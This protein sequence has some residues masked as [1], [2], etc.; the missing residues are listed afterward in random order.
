[1]STITKL[2]AG[3]KPDEKFFSLEFFPPKT[4]NGMANFRAR[5]ARMAAL[6]PLFITITW[7]AGGSTAKKSLDIASECQTMGLDV[8]L[9]L[10][11]TNMDPALIDQALEAASKA[12]ICN[13]LA[14][15]GDPP[16]GEEYWQPASPEFQHAADLVKYIK[17]KHGD[18]FCVGVAGYPEGHVDGSDASHQD[19]HH[20]LPYLKEKVEA[21]ADFIITQMFYDDTKFLEYNKAVREFS[22]LLKDITI[23]PGLMPINTYTSFV[24]AARLSHASVPP[25]ILDRIQA[26]PTGNDQQVK[27]IG[28]EVVSDIVNDVYSKTNKTVRGFH[29]YTLNLERSVARILERSGFLTVEEDIAVEEGTGSTASTTPNK[30]P[31]RRRSSASHR[32]RVVDDAR[33]HPDAPKEEPDLTTLALAIASGEGAVGREAVWDDFPN[34]RFGDS[35]SPAFGEIDGYGPSIHVPPARALELWGYPVDD[36]D[37]SKL[38][39]DTIVGKL[40]FMPWSDQT[41][42][43]E[44]MLIQE[45]LMELNQKGIWTVASQ[46]ACNALKSDD[47]IFGWGPKG[48]YVFQKS[49][50]EFF[51]SPEQWKKL[52]PLLDAQE[53]LVSYYVAK[54]DQLVDTNVTERASNG[55]TWGV[56]PNREIV[57]TTIIQEDSFDAWR[58]EAFSIW[59]EWR[60]LYKKNTASFKLLDK[61][62]N[63]YLLVTV[64][65]HDYVEEDGLWELLGSV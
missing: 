9:H 3:L 1:M 7:G 18:K 14:L 15:R 36:K 52:K 61:I 6:K 38:F 40:P 45:Q 56:F 50:A 31:L 13:I 8:C 41:L 63:E 21:G 29:F 62:I 30:T 10:T 4:Q 12:G 65:H 27:D 37:L 53:D 49:F 44:T 17:K 19:F 25:A 51:I 58:E 60:A 48:G 39:A 22:P 54:S 43:P 26:V 11:C 28:V 16:R 24:R 23:I 2:I 35:S 20:D 33:H 59:S 46:P 47:N 5:L 34:G 64:I 42:S 32:N 55:V 57:Q